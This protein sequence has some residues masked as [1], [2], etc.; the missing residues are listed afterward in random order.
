MTTHDWITGTLIGLLIA[1]GCNLDASDIEDRAN[2][3]QAISD[4]KMQAMRERNFE[5]AA[6]K[7]CGNADFAVEEDGAVVCKKRRLRKQI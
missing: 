4:A 3:F 7:M 1:A 5:L 6:A 2:Q